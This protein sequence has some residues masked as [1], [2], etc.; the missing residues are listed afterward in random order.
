MPVGIWF[1]SSIIN[2]SVPAVLTGPGVPWVEEMLYVVAV[3]H[4]WEWWLPDSWVLLPTPAAT[5]SLPTQMG[6]DSTL[7]K[8]Y[9]VTWTTSFLATGPFRLGFFHTEEAEVFC[10]GLP[11]TPKGFLTKSFCLKCHWFSVPSL[12]VVFFFLSIF[13]NYKKAF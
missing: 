10:T 3:I 6:L 1:I 8:G 4:G 11:G 12:C 9:Q 2:V 13:H 5:L 7:V